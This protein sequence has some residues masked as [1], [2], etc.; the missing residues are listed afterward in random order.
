MEFFLQIELTKMDRV[1][2]YSFKYETKTS[3]KMGYVL[4]LSNKQKRLNLLFMK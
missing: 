1:Q 4:L 3:P 2:N